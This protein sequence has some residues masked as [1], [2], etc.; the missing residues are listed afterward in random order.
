MLPDL[1]CAS[2][3]QGPNMG[4]NKLFGQPENDMTLSLTQP[5]NTASE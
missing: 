2:Y 1:S 4:L 3:G 5:V